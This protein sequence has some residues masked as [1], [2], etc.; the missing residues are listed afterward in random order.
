MPYIGYYLPASSRITIL[1]IHCVLALQ[2][3]IDFIRDNFKKRVS[4]V[5]IIKNLKLCI[6]YISFQVNIF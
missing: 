2:N 5:L 6:D 1:D 3:F 4:D